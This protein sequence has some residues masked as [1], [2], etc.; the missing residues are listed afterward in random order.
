MSIGWFSQPTVK[1]IEDILYSYHEYV[2]RMEAFEPRL[3]PSY[4]LAPSFSD[5]RN[6]SK[7]ED[8]II[9]RSEYPE[10]IQQIKSKKD[11]LP[12]KQQRLLE[13]KYFFFRYDYEI[14]K[15]LNINNM[16]YYQMRR[17]IIEF[18]SSIFGIS[19]KINEISS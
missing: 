18:F 2:E 13:M 6:H 7:I 8:A 5:S 14:W 1:Q 16:Q 17:E 9:S 19:I 15:E 11:N 3:G 12:E 4:S 10:L